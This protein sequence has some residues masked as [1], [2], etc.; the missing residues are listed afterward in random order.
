MNCRKRSGNLSRNRDNRCRGG[1][2]VRC[3]PNRRD[4]R[5]RRHGG[6]TS[7]GA[8][9]G[10]RPPGES[11]RLG[12]ASTVAPCGRSGLRVA[13]PPRRGVPVPRLAGLPVVDPGSVRGHRH[14]HLALPSARAR[15]LRRAP[16]R[17]D[18][19]DVCPEPRAHAA[20]GG[21]PSPFPLHLSAP[22]VGPQVRPA[23]PERDSATLLRAQSGPGQHAVEP[24]ERGHD[25]ERLRGRVHVGVRERPAA[26]LARPGC[27]SRLVRARVRF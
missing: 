13:S 5:R 16:G 8:R 10:S 3:N 4:S 9:T 27:P 12:M 1:R 20:R 23:R 18:T 21:R 22:G 17:L 7:R 14:R 19:S 26:V 6:C 11:G 25:M 2:C 15:T 24:R